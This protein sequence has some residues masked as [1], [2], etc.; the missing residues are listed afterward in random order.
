MIETGDKG[1]E[2]P[3]EYTKNLAT[4]Q[5][6]IKIGKQLTNEKINKQIVKSE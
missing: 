2:P 3:T 1:R 5:E 4:C 6:T